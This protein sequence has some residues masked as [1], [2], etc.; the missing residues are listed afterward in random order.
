VADKIVDVF[1]R[2][3]LV[4]TYTMAWDLTHTP[5]FE[6]DFIDRARERLKADGY[7]AQQVAEARFSIRD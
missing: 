7:T 5:L 6:Q 1:L 2:D 4:Q 3:V